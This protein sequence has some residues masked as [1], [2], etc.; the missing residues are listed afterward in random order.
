LGKIS[1]DEEFGDG[2]QSFILGKN[3]LFFE[4]YFALANMIL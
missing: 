3:T 2:C 4:T 1:S